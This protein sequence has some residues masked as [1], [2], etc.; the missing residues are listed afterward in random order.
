MI[1]SLSVKEEKGKRLDA[2]RGRKTWESWRLTR[3]VWKPKSLKR[4]TLEL[5]KTGWRI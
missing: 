1:S 5:I 4:G 2:S 3:R